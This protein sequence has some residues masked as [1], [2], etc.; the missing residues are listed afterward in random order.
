VWYRYSQEQFNLFDSSELS[1][2]HNLVSKPRNRADYDVENLAFY[3]G[4]VHWMNDGEIIIPGSDC[5]K[6][7]K[8]STHNLIL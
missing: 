5:K 7:I 8:Y 6:G 4:S 2:I 1:Q 3:H